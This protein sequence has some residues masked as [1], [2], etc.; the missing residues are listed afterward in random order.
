MA[1]Y[2][3]IARQSDDVAPGRYE[4]NELPMTRLAPQVALNPGDGGAELR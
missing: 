3:D 1:L 4:P 2:F